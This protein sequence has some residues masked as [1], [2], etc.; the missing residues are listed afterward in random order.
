MKIPQPQSVLKFSQLLDGFAEGAAVI[1]IR[2]WYKYSAE[3]M[4][5]AKYNQDL[6][7]LGIDEG[8]AEIVEH[9]A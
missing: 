8:W 7:S 4:A 1:F 3:K 2:R 6:L 9:T 5:M